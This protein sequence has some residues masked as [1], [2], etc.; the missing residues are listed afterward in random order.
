MLRLKILASTLPLI[1]AG[2]FAHNELAPAVR[3]CITLGQTSV[4]MAT[5]PW[6]A[7]LFVTFTRDP[8]AAT[9][10]VQTVDSA[11][12]AD[13]V[14]V[15]DADTPNTTSCEVTAATSFVAIGAAA[16]AP[17]IY[18]SRDGNAD[19][20]IFVRSKTFTAREAAALIVGASSEH[21]NPAAASL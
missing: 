14:M 20:R 19:Y 21:P 3:P 8:A 10:R 9:V 11:E 18:L 13:F 7:R 4:Q 2:A 6:Q 17:V 1:L 16:G 12:A 5:A 15:D